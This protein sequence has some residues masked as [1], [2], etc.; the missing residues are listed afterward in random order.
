[1]QISIELAYL[2]DMAKLSAAEQKS[3]LSFDH[4]LLKKGAKN[5]LDL[6]QFSFAVVD[7]IV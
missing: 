2:G 3:M 4:V 6:S 5:L 7:L 1:V